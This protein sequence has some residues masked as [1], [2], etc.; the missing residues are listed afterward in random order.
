[1]KFAPESFDPAEQPEFSVPSRPK[2]AEGASPQR[3]SAPV[4]VSDPPFRQLTGI[5]Y[6]R[7]GL[8]VGVAVLG[9]CLAG[10]VGLL[11]PPK[12]TAKAQ[13]VVEPQAG[14]VNGQTASAPLADEPA[15]DTQVTMLTS[16][17]NL[18]RVVDSLA[19]NPESLADASRKSSGDSDATSPETPDKNA[20][21]STAAAEKLSTPAGKRIVPPTLDDLER[22][23]RVSQER[24]SRVIG[25]SYTS[26]DPAIAAAIANRIVQLFVDG[27]SEQK[28]E[29]ANRELARLDDR[30][31]E[32]KKEVEQAGAAVQKT[33]QQR[34]AATQNSPGEEREADLRL[35]ELER[36]GSARDQLYTNLVRRQK[37]LRY[38]QEIVASDVR[39]LSLASPPDRP[40]SPSPL[41]F[42]FPA[43]VLFSMGGCLLA[44]AAERLDR[45]LR[46]EQEVVD[47]LGLPCL[48]LVSQLSRTGRIRP[49]KY[50]L[51][52]P[53]SAYTEAIRSVVAGLRLTTPH[54]PSKI[55]LTS[56]SVPS[57]G[58]TTLAVS[59]AVYIAQIR[60]R[61]LLVDLD[62]RHPT[63]QRALRTRAKRG[64]VDL[65]LHDLPP[66]DVIQRVPHLGLDFLPMTRC[67]VDPVT[68]FAGDQLTRLLHQLRESYDCV[69]VDGPPLLGVTE[70]RLL[71]A[72]ADKVLFVVKWGSTR[73]ETAQNAV[74]VLRSAGCLDQNRVQPSTVL[75]QV[76]LKE[77]ARYRYGDVGEHFVKYEKYY[78]N[79]VGYWRPKLSLPKPPVSVTSE[80]D[81]QKARVPE[82]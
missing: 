16:H 29:I 65:L 9:T 15:I 32:L 48:G 13:I 56:S 62:F 30:I 55:I 54:E 1:M 51:R 63:V 23:L 67:P 36:E 66:A 52:H 81:L 35:R 28:R 40:S 78:S 74:N 6:R 5:L 4:Q 47:A 69:I 46:S 33:V 41:L 53:F 25:V 70:S 57:E 7:I 31:A 61:V 42:I 14:Q 50:L 3:A 2:E 73:R 20:V 24:T 80:D 17:D 22:Y 27:Q 58:K 43:F 72:M 12:Y 45:G 18:Q 49:H 59:L 79:S 38:Q 75:T 44:V 60:R 34:L 76:D 77:H 19:K 37:E 68:L 26:T 39:I 8:V 82:A 64:V 71:A 21:S 11:I 10:A